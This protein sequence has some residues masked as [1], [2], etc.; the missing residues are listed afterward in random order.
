M[1]QNDCVK[2]N[3]KCVSSSAL[4]YSHSLERNRVDVVDLD[5]YGTAAP[6]ID[7]AVQCITD[8]GN[9]TALHQSRPQF[10]LIQ[11]RSSVCD[12]HGPL[13]PGN[14]QLPGEMVRPVISNVTWCHY[15]GHCNSYSNYGG[16]SVKAE[17]S[18]EA[19]SWRY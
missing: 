18:H 9:L 19:V 8:G 13:R 2:I 7:A 15:L 6:F 14:Q 4:M 17:Y 1:F 5:P 3:E 12:M 11:R 16:I 10:H